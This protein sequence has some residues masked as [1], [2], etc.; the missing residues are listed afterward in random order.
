MKYISILFLAISLVFCVNNPIQADIILSG[1]SNIIDPLTGTTNGVPGT[2]TGNQRFFTNILGGGNSVAVLQSS[3]S[4]A[5]DLIAD[6]NTFYNGL[7]GVTSTTIGGNIT[8]L[9]GY[10]LLVV[11]LPDHTFTSG[12]TALLSNFLAAGN[13]IIFTGENSSDVFTTSNTNINVDLTALGS[14]MQ[15]VA[16]YIDSGYFH[17]ASGSR[18]VT[19]PLT[20]GVTTLSYAASSR[21]TGGSYLVYGSYGEPII[22]TSGSK[23]VPE[24]A[25]MLLLGFGLAGLAGVRKFKS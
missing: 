17:T 7:S 23:A 13:S 12:E 2:D 1:D 24:P 25:T 5:S 20:T 4:Y 16:D 15:I 22:E 14:S 9:A 6:V 3:T 10:N 18:I 8:S 19:N 21:V 11:I